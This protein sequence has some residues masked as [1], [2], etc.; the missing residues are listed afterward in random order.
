M[1][2]SNSKS[3]SK[4]KTNSKSKMV[5]RGGANQTNAELTQFL[6]I[7]TKTKLD[8]VDVVCSV[9]LYI[10]ICSYNK[11]NDHYSKLSEKIKKKWAT[12][13]GA[14]LFQSASN[15]VGSFGKGATNAITQGAT[16]LTEGATAAGKLA[17][18]T[19]TQGTTTLTQGAT[20][21]GKLASNAAV[22][23]AS[24]ATGV[25][26]SASALAGSTK[27]MFFP[28]SD[29][30]LDDALQSIEE[31][32]TTNGAVLKKKEI[33]ELLIILDAVTSIKDAIQKCNTFNEKKNYSILS[34][35]LK[36]NFE[37]L[38]DISYPDITK[39]FKEMIENVKPKTSSNVKATSIGG[40]KR[41][42]KM[43]KSKKRKSYKRR[44][45]RK[46]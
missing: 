45:S 42:R 10:R 7:D 35:L 3:K 28:G 27:N 23:A 37:S 21:A 44:K 40:Y 11:S 15:A 36:I 4:S 29:D 9:L 5:K 31:E 2:K 16:T 41:T 6:T 46:Y 38:Q 33:M 26:S 25:A 39:K 19:I 14:S 18:N 30:I 22:A 34:I 8:A 43:S 32:S 12:R 1:A 20:A 24:T 13:G 17:S